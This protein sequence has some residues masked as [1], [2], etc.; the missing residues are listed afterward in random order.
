MIDVDEGMAQKASTF[1]ML[2][3]EAFHFLEEQ[4]GYRLESTSIVGTEDFRDTTARVVYLG[5]HVAV[6]VSWYLADA[7][8]SVGFVELRDPVVLPAYWNFLGT[9]RNAPPAVTLF[10][11]AEMQGHAQDPDF[12]LGDPA[13]I[14][15][16]K[17][18]ARQRLVETNLADILAALARATQRYAADILAGDTSCFPDVMRLYVKKTNIYAKKTKTGM[19]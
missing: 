4:Y 2:T 8:I 7:G 1:Y 11:L 6:R 3:Q 17:L 13:G 9:E 5:E 19:A 16:P 14:G 15:K 18:P 12:L 10:T